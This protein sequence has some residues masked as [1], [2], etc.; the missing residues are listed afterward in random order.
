MRTCLLIAALLLVSGCGSA[1][2]DK[3]DGLTSVLWVQTS[4]E[5]D[6]L[7]RQAYLCASIALDK[8]IANRSSTAALEQTE[9]IDFEALPVAIIIDV[10]ETVLDN[11]PYQAAL[12]LDGRSYSSK[13]WHE[14]VMEGRA[15]PISGAVTFLSRAVDLGISIFYVTNRTADLEA[16]TRTNLIAAG[17]PLRDDDDAVMSKGEREDWGSDKATRRQWIARTHRIALLIGDD[18][19]DFISPARGDRAQRHAL[20]FPHRARWGVNWIALPN[21]LYGSFD[22]SILHGATI[23]EPQDRIDLR[24]QALRR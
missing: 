6:A 7:C 12:A 11:S 13:T 10:D 3:S 21:P 24:R 9:Q 23:A 19:G 17:F 18:L 4:E 2:A 14:W 1:P 20:V 8:A 5:Y 22:R 16:A 15:R